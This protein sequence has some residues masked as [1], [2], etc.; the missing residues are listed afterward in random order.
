MH[1]C[2]MPAV[3]QSTDTEIVKEREKQKGSGRGERE[4]RQTYYEQILYY[5]LR[6][7]V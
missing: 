4:R 5:V 6:Q 3:E 1:T 7:N 2:I